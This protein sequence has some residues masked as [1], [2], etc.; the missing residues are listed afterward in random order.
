MIE[1]IRDNNIPENN[2]NGKNGL[3]D[4]IKNKIDEKLLDFYLTETISDKLL[5]LSLKDPISDKLWDKTWKTVEKEAKEEYQ[6]S[7][8]FGETEKGREMTFTEADSGNV[9]PNFEECE[10]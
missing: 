10:G 2:A 7:D 3:L 6:K 5:D 1:K 9:N 8:F 4:D